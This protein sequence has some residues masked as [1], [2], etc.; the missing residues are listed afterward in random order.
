MSHQDQDGGTSSPFNFQA[1]NQAIQWLFQSVVLGSIDFRVD[2]TWSP[3]GFIVTAMLWAWSDEDTLTGRFTAARRVCMK[4]LGAL[5][6]GNAERPATSYQAFTKMMQT[7]TESLIQQAATAFRKHMCEALRDRFR[8]AGFALFGVDGT[9]LELPRTASNEKAFSPRPPDRQAPAG[10][11][12]RRRLRKLAKMRRPRRNRGA[13][14]RANTPLMW[15]T[16]MWHIGTGLPWD[17]RIG[18]SDSSERDHLLEMI[19]CLPMLALVVADAGFVGYEYWKALID[20]NRHFLIRVGAN[21][22]LLRELGYARNAAGRVYLW[23]NHVAAKKLP[24]LVLRLVKVRRGKKTWYLVTS[25]L[26]QQRLSDRQVAEIYG[27]RWGIELFY[28]HFKQTFGRRKLRSKS[29]RNAV[30]EA[31][32]SLLGLWAMALHTQHLLAP[33]RIPARRVSVAKLLRAYRKVMDQYKT[34][35]DPGQSLTELLRQAVTDTYTRSNKASR[36]YPRKKQ[37]RAAGMP[38]ITRA[39]RAQVKSAQAFKDKCSRVGLTA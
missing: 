18:P 12:T 36:D 14:K 32:W 39:T 7:W 27:S 33:Q 13:E 20:S 29:A 3:L 8:I 6:L 11:R 9:R 15:L 31:H 5:A 28:R 21:V 23:P 34:R 26:D 35:P 17:W 37:D 1:L 10:K 25:V 22:H 2:C 30:V 4:V 16:T 24:P 38:R 19:G